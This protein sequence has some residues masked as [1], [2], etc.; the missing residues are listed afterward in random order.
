MTKKEKGSYRNTGKAG[1]RGTYQS[2]HSVFIMANEG[3]SFLF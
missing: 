2:G 3:T 1:K